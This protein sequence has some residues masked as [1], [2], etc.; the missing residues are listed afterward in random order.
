MVE[1]FFRQWYDGVDHEFKVCKK[2]QGFKL[3]KIKRLIYIKNMDG[4]FNKEEPIKNTVEV[5]FYY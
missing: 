1:V 3:K 5:N 2:K 4:T